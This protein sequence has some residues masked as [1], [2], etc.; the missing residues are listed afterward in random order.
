LASPLGCPSSDAFSTPPV[1]DEV[2]SEDFH[3]LRKKTIP[4]SIRDDGISSICELN[5]LVN[6]P[7]PRELSSQASCP[8]GYE[9]LTVIGPSSTK[10]LVKKSNNS[11]KERN[12]SIPKII[13]VASPTNCI[14]KATAQSLKAIA[15]SS[16]YTIYIHSN[17]AM[18]RFILARRWD[19]VFPEVKD[20][21]FCT[22]EK[23]KRYVKFA[24]EEK[25][26]YQN[27]HRGEHVIVPKGNVTSP[28]DDDISEKEREND[29]NIAEEIALQSIRDIWK[30]LILW[31]YGGVVLQDLNTLHAILDDRNDNR[32]PNDKSNHDRLLQFVSKEGQDAILFWNVG[33]DHDDNQHGR[34]VPVTQIL[35]SRPY[36]PLLFFTLKWALKWG[37]DDIPLPRGAAGPPDR[38]DQAM[39]NAFY[40]EGRVT[41]I[42]PLREG[43]F[44]FLPNHSRLPIH[45]IE[46]DNDESGGDDGVKSH[47]GKDGRKISFVNGNVILPSSLLASSSATLSSSPPWQPILHAMGTKYAGGDEDD[48]DAI[49]LRLIHSQDLASKLNQVL[50][51]CME[52]RLRMH[53]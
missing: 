6:L 43:L 50:F 16:K 13:H 52:Y 35:A 14:P 47:T 1:A 15:T 7:P 24:L 29:N 9:F 17:F 21:A 51:S 5:K 19:D 48:G 18:D 32:G 49:V 8:S 11:P 31:E 2:F 37:M 39:N 12:E 30:Y 25:K 33:S 53:S 44:D 4:T 10:G 38:G 28:S 41:D 20:G 34:R 27:H 40:S 23:V 42:P 22:A 46:I 36:H 26:L 45:D 3:D